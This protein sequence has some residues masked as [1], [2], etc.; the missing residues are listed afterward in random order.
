[1]QLQWERVST[2]HW[3]DRTRKEG[4]ERSNKDARG[5][6]GVAR[7]EEGVK[8]AGKH[9]ERATD[10]VPV[11]RPSQIQQTEADNLAGDLQGVASQEATEA[12]KQV[13]Q[14]MEERAKRKRL[15]KGKGQTNKS[16]T[17]RRRGGQVRDLQK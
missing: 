14:E 10:F 13:E 15:D 5:G 16:L 9:D 3:R 7:I 2:Q 12:M 1:M 11:E 8:V 17:W 6:A 4:C